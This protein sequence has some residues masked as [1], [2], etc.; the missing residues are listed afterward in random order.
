VI[1]YGAG[2]TAMD[3]A[4]TAKRLGADEATIVF[5]MDRAHME[6]HE[7]EAKEALSEGIKIKWLTS[8]RDIGMDDILIERM[9]MDQQASRNPPADSRRLRPP[10]W[11]LPSASRVTPAFYETCPASPSRRTVISSSMPA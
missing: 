6:A 9:E 5:I 4:R 11:F 2:N 10:P 3:A 7:F 8:I 1:V